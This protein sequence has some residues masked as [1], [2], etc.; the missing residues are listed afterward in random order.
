MH[1]RIIDALFREL[2]ADIKNHFVGND[3]DCDYCKRLTD[4]EQADT[5]YARTVEAVR[6]YHYLT[7]Q[8]FTE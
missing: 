6:A 4:Q 5:A 2:V 8:P 3:P 7:G 1:Q